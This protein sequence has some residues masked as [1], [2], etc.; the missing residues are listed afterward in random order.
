MAGR[1]TTQSPPLRRPGGVPRGVGPPPCRRLRAAA[2]PRPSTMTRW[3]EPCDDLDAC[4]REHDHCV[5]PARKGS[6]YRISESRLFAASSTLLHHLVTDGNAA[7]VWFPLYAAAVL[8]PICCSVINC[9]WLVNLLAAWIGDMYFGLGSSKGAIVEHLYQLSRISSS[10][11]SHYDQVHSGAV[12][13]VT[14]NVSSRSNRYDFDLH[15]K[16]ARVTTTKET[17]VRLSSKTQ[18]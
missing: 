15:T 9:V 16:S 1:A 8:L 14:E 5:C 6:G 13:I 17:G 2:R 4:S 12:M 3:E 11:G 18:R 7:A 10:H